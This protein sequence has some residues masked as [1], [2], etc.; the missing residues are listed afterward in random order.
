MRIEQIDPNFLAG[1]NL[2]G[3]DFVWKDA[4]NGEFELRGV[5]KD[6]E[7]GFIRIP[8]D[9]LTHFSEYVGILSTHTA[10]GRFRFRTN[11][12]AIAFRAKPLHSGMMSHMPL[13]GSDGLDVYINGKFALCVRPV[14]TNCEWFEGMYQNNQGEAEVEINMPLY[15]GIKTLLIGIE[16]GEVFPA[17]KYTVE[18]PVIYYGSSITQGGC[19]SRPGNSYQGFVSRELD[20]DHINLGFSGNAKGEKEMAEYIASIDSAAFVMDYDHN[21]PTSEHLQNTHEPFFKVIREKKPLLPVIFISRPNYESNPK[22]SDIRR[23]II[24]KT[25]E[26]AVN[27]GDRLVWFIDGETLFGKEERDGCTVDGA[28]PN[29]FGFYRMAKTIAPVLKEAL[30]R[31]AEENK[32]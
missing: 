7:S 19:A 5:M 10:G 2:A 30:E 12:S 25:Y 6:E 26:N 11:A 32:R 29:D 9:V 8:R 21:A 4:C 22:E 14:G 13:T 20:T 31:A 17:R 24:Y 27:A 18:Q 23:S 16:D 3:R 15:N 28:H 1:S